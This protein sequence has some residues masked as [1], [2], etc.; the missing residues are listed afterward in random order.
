MFK[1]NK[2]AFF[3]LLGNKIADILKIPELRHFMVLDKL[4]NPARDTNWLQSDGI[5]P[6]INQLY[7]AIVVQQYNPLTR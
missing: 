2:L 6:K 3:L 5:V 4:P 1:H 7:V